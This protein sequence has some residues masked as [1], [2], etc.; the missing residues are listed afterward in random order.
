MALWRYHPTKESTAAMFRAGV[1]ISNEAFHDGYIR[2]HVVARDFTASIHRIKRVQET[3]PH[4]QRE[5]NIEV[6]RIVRELDK[7]HLAI[8]SIV[9][10]YPT[11]LNVCS[12]ASQ[13][14]E[15]L[16]NGPIECILDN[17]SVLSAAKTE[18]EAIIKASRS[19]AELK[20]MNKYLANTLKIHLAIVSASNSDMT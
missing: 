15:E 19:L 13:A 10:S 14:L 16:E 9:T 12:G 1:A 6:C 5:V 20:W 3:L 8:A 11:V 4:F 7:A 2:S 18:C 17:P